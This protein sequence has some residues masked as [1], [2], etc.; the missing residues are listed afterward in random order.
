MAVLALNPWTIVCAADTW[1]KK[2]P[3]GHVRLWLCLAPACLSKTF[4]SASARFAEVDMQQ[5]LL[6]LMEKQILTT[7][8][9]CRYPGNKGLRDRRT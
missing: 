6:A 8:A 4:A 9:K 3:Q 5:F 7:R 2:R 1:V